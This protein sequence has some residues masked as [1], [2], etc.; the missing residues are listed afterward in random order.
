M[1]TAVSFENDWII[2][3]SFFRQL[4][5]RA[6]GLEQNTAIVYEHTPA[7]GDSRVSDNS[8][9]APLNWIYAPD[10]SGSTIPYYIYDLRL[11]SYIVLPALEN[12][13][14]LNSDYGEFSFTGSPENML[15]VQFAPP[16]CL[17]VL[18]PPFEGLYP[19][20]PD[21]LAHSV[22]YS[23]P[24][25][26]DPD[27]IS[28]GR[29]PIEIF[30]S[31]PEPGWC[32]YFQQADAAR[33]RGDWKTVAEIG[34]LAFTLIDQPKQPSERIPFI[35]AYGYIGRWDRAEE[36][37]HETSRRD[38]NAQPMLC[39]VWAELEVDT[40]DTVEK[41]STIQRVMAKLNCSENE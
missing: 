19:H 12:D 24:G 8:L 17:Q 15:L 38:K 41:N 35:Q 31:E 29:L 4:A 18:Q 33:Q 30:P 13:Q 6:P 14:S 39:L 3:E 11:R 32:Y 22:N 21:N 20:L 27:P 26:I 10:V 34:D 5:W 37:T 16:W 23:N 7:L 1:L 9:T 36:L 28:P 2:Q 25:V 40:P